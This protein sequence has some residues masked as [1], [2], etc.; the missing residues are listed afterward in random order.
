MFGLIHSSTHGEGG[1]TTTRPVP[2]PTF[3]V[4]LMLNGGFAL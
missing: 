4:P 3:N 1:P 2:G